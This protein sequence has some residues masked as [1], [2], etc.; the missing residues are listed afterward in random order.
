MRVTLLSIGCCLLSTA[1]LATDWGPWEPPQPG[2]G[3]TRQRDPAP[4]KTAIRL[5]QKYISA[6]DGP[7]CSMYPTCSTYS[8][9][10][11]Q[12]HGPLLGIFQTVDRLY[13]EGDP[14]E[15]QRPIEKWGYIRFNDPLE[16]NDFWLKLPE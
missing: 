5:F 1:V 12:K 13:H 8:L 10:A 14:H 2:H 3:I 7:R 6:V 15:R 16:N 11:L 9:Q 4:L